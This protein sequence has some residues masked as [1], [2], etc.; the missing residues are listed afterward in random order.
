MG[1]CHCPPHPQLTAPPSALSLGRRAPALSRV[2]APAPPGPSRSRPPARR[3]HGHVAPPLRRKRFASRVKVACGVFNLRPQSW[4]PLTSC[5]PLWDPS[6]LGMDRR[7]ETQALPWDAGRLGWR[8]PWRGSRG[9]V[10][11]ASCRLCSRRPGSAD[12]NRRQS[13]PRVPA[14][15]LSWAHGGPASDLPTTS[16]DPR[17]RPAQPRTSAGHTRCTGN[18]AKSRLPSF[19]RSCVLAGVCR[20]RASPSRCWARLWGPVNDRLLSLPLA[21]CA[22]SQTH[23]CTPSTFQDRWGAALFLPGTLLSLRRPL[24]ETCV[25]PPC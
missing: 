9:S 2:R 15:R 6:G 18:D 25:C 5:Q 3:P 13:S 22:I 1:T 20:V 17:S 16:P 8:R 4:R 10:P 21:L 19:P 7:P 12:L 11:A 23:N 24:G 14:A